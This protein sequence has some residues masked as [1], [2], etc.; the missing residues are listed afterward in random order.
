MRR[1]QDGAVP[2]GHEQVLAIFQAV[3]AG[4]SSETL[5]ALFELFQQAEVARDLGRHGSLSFFLYLMMRPSSFVLLRS[6]IPAY[7][8]CSNA[9]ILALRSNGSSAA[10]VEDMSVRI[11]A[12]RIIVG[13]SLNIKNGAAVPGAGQ[14]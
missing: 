6:A 10:K 5:F 11:G 7:H 9:C 4:F 14:F 8:G 3:A 13:V 12:V 2:V 1:P